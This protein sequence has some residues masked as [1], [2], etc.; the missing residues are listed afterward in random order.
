MRR[1]SGG[2]VEYLNPVVLTGLGLALALSLGLDVTGA[3]TGVESL[4]AGLLG[5]T[6]TLLLDA[7]ARAEQRF[8]LRGA[9]EATDWLRGE[10]RS[11]AAAVREISQQQPAAEIA[12]ETHQRFTRLR[13]GLDDLRQGRI[14]RPGNDYEL[15]MSATGSCRERMEAVTNLVSSGTGGYRWWRADHGRRYWEANLAA[16]ARG[17]A[18]TRIFICASL[19]ED[20]RAIVDEQ[21]EAGVNTVLVKADDVDPTARINLVVWDG[22]RAWTSDMNAHGDTVGNVFCVNDRDL[23]RL[24]AAFDACLHAGHR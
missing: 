14:V 5:A 7:T 20:V 15:L 23:R 13:E 17:V 1:R 4:L 18:I 10:V 3:A 24:G 6:I 22:R 2:L 11:L 9:L 19:T 16:L 21:R 12:A 8:E